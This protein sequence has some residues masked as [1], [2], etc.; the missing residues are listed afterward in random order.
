MRNPVDPGM[1]GLR[2]CSFNY[3]YLFVLVAVMLRLL[4]MLRSS[5][6]L[7]LIGVRDS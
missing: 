4:N 1:V 2:L 6:G 5:A 7:A 3:T